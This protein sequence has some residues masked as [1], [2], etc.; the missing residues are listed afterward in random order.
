MVFYIYIIPYIFCNFHSILI[1]Q[2]V[3]AMTS[4]QGIK[5]KVCLRIKHLSIRSSP[6][7]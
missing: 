4:E 1:L 2:T 3:T 7:R 5:K 6:V